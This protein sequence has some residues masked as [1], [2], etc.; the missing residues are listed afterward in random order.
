MVVAWLLIAVP[1][2]LAI[3]PIEL[4]EPA[5]QERYRDLTHELRCMQCQN[6][7][8][9]DSP[10]GLAG[11]LRREVIRHPRTGA[12]RDQDRCR[13]LRRDRGVFECVCRVLVAPSPMARQGGASD[14]RRQH[15]GARDGR[16]RAVRLVQPLDLAAG[17]H[18]R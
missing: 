6:Q 16:R 3:D 18:Q 13:H 17:R 11:D 1:R 2:A 9:A 14:R 12:H 5:L 10:V 15:G 7:S 8:I 4:E